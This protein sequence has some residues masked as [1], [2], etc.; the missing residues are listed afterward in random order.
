MQLSKMFLRQLSEAAG[1]TP[2]IYDFEDRLSVHE[3]GSPISS[4][5]YYANNM[6]AV[7]NTAG[8]FTTLIWDGRD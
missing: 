5:S 2:M 3:S 6:K 4:F 1:L 7:E 8:A